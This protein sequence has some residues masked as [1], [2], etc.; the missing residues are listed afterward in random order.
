[1]GV[2]GLM[3]QVVQKPLPKALPA[4]AWRNNDV[5]QLPV[6]SHMPR[7]QKTQGSRHRISP[8]V[9]IVGFGEQ[10]EPC[11]RV[12]ASCEQLMV[13]L[14][15]PMSR[16]GALPFQVHHGSK[17]TRSRAPDRDGG[18]EFQSLKGWS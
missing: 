6:E 18:I 1:V 11:Y 7:D 4:S 8:V 3:Q 15:R 12:R 5:L 9:W 13:L 16:S 10:H 14:F 2:S 17:I